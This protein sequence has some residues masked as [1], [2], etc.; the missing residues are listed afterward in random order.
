MLNFQPDPRDLEGQK[1]VDLSIAEQRVKICQK[2]ENLNN[3]NTCKA[4]GCWIPLK[5][6]LWFTKCPIDKWPK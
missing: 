3:W 6:R 2:C 4:C 5:A 1:L